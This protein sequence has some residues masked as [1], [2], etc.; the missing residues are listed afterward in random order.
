MIS[1]TTSETSIWERR[2]SDPR[3]LDLAQSLNAGSRREQFFLTETE[4]GSGPDVIQSPASSVAKNPRTSAGNEK[5]N[6]KDETLIN[7]LRY[8]AC[9]PK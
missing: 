5:K 9:R 7:V 3:N 2:F 1:S 8:F 4:Q 6:G